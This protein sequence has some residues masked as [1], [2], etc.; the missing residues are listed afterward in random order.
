MKKGELRQDPVR[1]FIVNGITYISRNINI[2]FI[3]F[4]SFIVVLGLFSYY[5]HLDKINIETSLKLAGKAQSVFFNGSL[6]EA[7]VKFERILSDYPNTLG[8]NQALIYL[9][10]F[11][12]KE[13]NKENFDKYLNYEFYNINDS[14]IKSSIF[15]M[16]SNN[17]YNQQLYN[18]SFANLNKIQSTSKVNESIMG[19]IDLID[20]YITEERYTEALS[21]LNI[22]N[23]DNDIGFNE[24]NYIEEM[25]SFIKHKMKI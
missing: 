22:L 15:R 3:I 10:N 5:K 13:N 1:E 11:S 8:A 20:L 17:F 6:D 12:I 21:N 2:V 19:K 25:L 7:K 23:I 14:Y 9:L 18:E 16:K 4:I 24:K